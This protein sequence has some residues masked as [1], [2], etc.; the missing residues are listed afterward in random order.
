MFIPPYEPLLKSIRTTKTDVERSGEV[1]IPA[2][3]LKL[4]LQMALAQVDFDEDSYLSANPD[5]RQAVQRGAIESGL[6]HFIGYGYFEGRS[7]GMAKVD[8]L[9][10]ERDRQV[11]QC[12]IAKR[13]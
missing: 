13:A 5:V 3:L 11:G 8:E 10:S 9:C 4:L 7:G 1:T 6:L 2:S 12:R